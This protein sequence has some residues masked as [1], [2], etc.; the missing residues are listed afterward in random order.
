M[1]LHGLEKIFVSLT[2]KILIDFI[3][4]NIT[5]STLVV[6]L[7]VDVSLITLVRSSA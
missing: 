6:F 2:N 1:W 7:G 3:T 5:G 4:I